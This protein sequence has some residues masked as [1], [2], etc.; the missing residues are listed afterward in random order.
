M[1][2][3]QNIPECDYDGGDCCECT[4]EDTPNQVCGLYV[5]FACI[6]PAAECV[7]DDSVTVDMV[8][9]CDNLRWVGEAG[10]I[11]AVNPLVLARVSKRL[12]H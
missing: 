7:D 11:L 1:R 6:D 8:G 2:T 9:V 10:A 12:D 4:C 5:G 3:L